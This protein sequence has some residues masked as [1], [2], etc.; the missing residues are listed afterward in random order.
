MTIFTILL[1]SIYTRRVIFLTLLVILDS[2]CI[3]S[4]SN[5]D[6]MVP[7]T[8]INPLGSHRRHNIVFICAAYAV[9]NKYIVFIYLQ[10][11]NI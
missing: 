5:I 10:Y 2:I 11:N 8:Q 6:L 7:L 3:L 1:E 9:E 4:R